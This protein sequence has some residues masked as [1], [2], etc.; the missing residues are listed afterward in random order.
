MTGGPSGV[1][2]AVAGSGQSVLS[3]ESYCEG[4]RDP[5]LGKT[6]S[7][8]ILKDASYIVYLDEDDYLEWGTVSGF[9]PPSYAGDILNQ[10]AKLQALPIASASQNQIRAFRT[11]QGE[12][13]ARALQ[14]SG[15]KTAQEAIDQSLE[16]LEKW[17]TERSRQFSLIGSLS[18]GLAAALAALLSWLSRDSLRAA[19]SPM[20][21]EV[22]LGACVGGV[23]ALLFVVFGIGSIRGRAFPQSGEREMHILDGGVRVLAG[24]LGGALVML[25]IHGNLLLGFIPESTGLAA[26]LAICMV[27]GASERLVPDLIERIEGGAK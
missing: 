3:Y 4:D 17:N 16:V 9:V 15:Q 11:L 1:G 8:L 10:V 5:Y 24:G 6:I 23:G 22:M 21:F 20:L 12:A 26:R 13:V 7:T 18:L 25:A 27:S 19:T 2:P 14:D